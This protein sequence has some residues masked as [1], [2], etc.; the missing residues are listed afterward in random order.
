MRALEVAGDSGHVHVRRGKLAPREVEQRVEEPADHGH[1]GTHGR[2][3]LEL[4]QLPG[5]ELAGRRREVGVGHAP[6]VAGDVLVGALPG[7]LD[8]VTQDAQ[9]LVQQQLALGALDALLHLEADLLLDAEHGVLFGEALEK[10]EKALLRTHDLEQ[11]LLLL[12]GDLQMRGDDVGEAR[13]G[14]AAFW[15]AN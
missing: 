1:L 13:P 7:L 11:R 15:T 5:D 10:G 14:S 3:L 6:G 12:A 2:R 8:L 9:L 4:G